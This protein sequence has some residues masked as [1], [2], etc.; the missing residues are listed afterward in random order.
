MKKQTLKWCESV[1]K[2][3]LN[4]KKMVMVISSDGRVSFC[5]RHLAGL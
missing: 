4:I 5:P 3:K 1:P 2:D